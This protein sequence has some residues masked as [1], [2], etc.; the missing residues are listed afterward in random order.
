[1]TIE[2]VRVI[3]WPKFHWIPDETLLS[4]VRLIESVSYYVVAT[5]KSDNQNNSLY[6][7]NEHHD[8]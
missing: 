5:E 2:E 8:R 3:L 1:M 7:E 4:F 6:I